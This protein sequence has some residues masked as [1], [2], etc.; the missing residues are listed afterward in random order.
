MAKHSKIYFNF[1]D[2]INNND[3]NPGSFALV[4]ETN[5]TTYAYHFYNSSYN[6]S[7]TKTEKGVKLKFPEGQNCSQDESYYSIIFDIE[8][9]DNVDIE[10][11]EDSFVPKQCQ[12]II[13][14]KSKYACS[15]SLYFDV[16]DILDTQKFIFGPLLIIVGLYLIV[17]GSKFPYFTTFVITASACVLLFLNLVFGFAHIGKDILVYCLIGGGIIAGLIISFIIILK[18]KKNIFGYIM[19]GVL[20]FVITGLCYNILLKFIY[21]NA[22]VVYWLTM[23]VCVVGLSIFGNQLYEI[24]ITIGTASTGAYAVVR[25]AALM[26]GKF[27]SES[28]VLELVSNKE[29]NELNALDGYYIYLYVLVWAILTCGGFFLQKYVFKNEDIAEKAKPDIYE[30]V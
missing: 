17:L 20:G 4:G 22:S 16:T 25:G 5:N 6:V 30:K 10:I 7:L 21:S 13:K 28:I 27:L 19:G 23:I 18:E 1:C 14:A 12:N 2:N 26:I 9:N 8:C 24:F 29:Y 15:Q 11:D 3:N